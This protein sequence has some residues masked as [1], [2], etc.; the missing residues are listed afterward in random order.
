MP[1]SILIRVKSQRNLRQAASQPE[2]VIGQGRD[3]RYHEKEK[4]AVD[5]TGNVFELEERER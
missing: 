5:W 2:R 1:A 4:K 3:R